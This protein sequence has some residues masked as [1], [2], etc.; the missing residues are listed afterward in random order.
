MDIILKYLNREEIIFLIYIILINLISFIAMGIDKKKAKKSNWRISENT[1][2]SLCIVGGSFG[3][4]VGM[5][6][7]KHKT[8]KKKFYILVPIINI[9][10]KII[11]LVILNT[12]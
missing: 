9:I 12:I 5:L 11:F 10:Q 3:N 7:Y 1:L 8:N 4:I 6:W 2:I